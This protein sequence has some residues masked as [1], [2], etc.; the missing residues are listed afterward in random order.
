MLYDNLNSGE[1]AMSESKKATEIGPEDHTQPDFTHIRKNLPPFLSRRSASA[2]IG[3]VLTPRTLANLD[4]TNNGPPRIRVG[5]KVV[6]ETD[7]FFKWLES[8][9]IT[10]NEEG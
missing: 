1:C 10:C 5:R 9:S 6:Y 3:G 2:A 4:C 7:K 8:K